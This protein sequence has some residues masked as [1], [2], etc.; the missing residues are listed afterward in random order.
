MKILVAT[1]GSRHA[2]EALRLVKGFDLTP[3]TQVEVVAVIPGPASSPGM[4][5]G[6]GMGRIEDRVR[7][8]VAQG[9]LEDAVQVLRRPGLE[10]LRTLLRGEPE[11]ALLEHCEEGGHDL[12]VA[13]VKGRGAGP[14]FELGRVAL[15]L[16]RWAPASV[17]LAR[18][19]RV[20]AGRGGE[21]LRGRITGAQ[22]EAA[23][24]APGLRILL[25][26]DG[27]ARCLEAAWQ[28]IESLTP[29]EAA[30]EVVSVAE[31]ALARAATP[32]G[33]MGWSSP[34][35]AGGEGGEPARRWLSQAVR[36][37]PPRRVASPGTLLHGRPASA[38]SRWAAAS[39]SDLM[40]VGTRR[41]EGSRECH[42]GRTGRELAWSTPCSV[43]M[44][45]A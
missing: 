9:W 31:P 4:G 33:E 11:T 27:D 1:D 13:G 6:G 15:H 26:T 43:L 10:P 34:G 30:V 21:A 29:E 12:V 40:V 39:G 19:P 2:R 17:L 20:G 37:L 16:V 24:D 22:M 32:A 8:E 42:I 23:G 38:I 28:M 3:D 25:P 18:R 5:D 44:V 45:R 7:P 35:G 14:F 41:L 36:E